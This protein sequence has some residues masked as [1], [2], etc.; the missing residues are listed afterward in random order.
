MPKNN[1]SVVVPTQR[2]MTVDEQIK[3]YYQRG[4]GS[5]QDLARI[6]N[7][8]VDHVLILVGESNLGT[9]STQ[10]DMID[11]TEVG[12]GAQINYGKQFKVPFTVD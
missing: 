9:V 1:E 7:V 5:I 3:F 4:K 10:G 12:P 8:S 6:F 11:A 2:E